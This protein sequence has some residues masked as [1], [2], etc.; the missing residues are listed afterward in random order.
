MRADFYR[1]PIDQ[2]FVFGFVRYRDQA[3]TY[4]SR[5]AVKLHVTETG[6]I[7][8]ATAGPPAWSRFT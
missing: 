8:M 6:Q 1:M 5:F 4:V 2:P 3:E 7:A